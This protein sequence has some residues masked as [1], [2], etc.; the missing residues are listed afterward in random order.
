MKIEF[1][2][3]ISQT[4]LSTFLHSLWIGI[5][6]SV[7]AA[8]VLIFT[9]EK[10]SKL[11]YTLLCSLFFLFLA[12]V[13]ASFIF[14]L[15]INL[16]NDGYTNENLQDNETLLP[17]AWSGALTGIND[18][19][20]ANCDY[21]LLVWAAVFLFRIIQVILDLRYVSRLKS[22][23]TTPVPAE[24]QHRFQLLAEKIGVKRS[25]KLF[26]SAL[27]KIPVIIG[28]F[29]PVILVPVGA[30]N[31]LPVADVEA[32]LL[33]E[34]AHIRRLDYLVNFIQCIAGAVFFFNPGLLWI[35]SLLRQER[36]NC[37]DD[38]AIQ[39]TNGKGQYV[40]ALISFKEFSIQPRVALGL[41]GKTSLL[42]KRV[43]RLVQ[44]RNRMLSIRELVFVML[45]AGVLFFFYIN[46]NSVKEIETRVSAHYL[47][48]PA[49]ASFYVSEK[50][51]QEEE[52]LENDVKTIIFPKKNNSLLNKVVEE[53]QEEE[54]IVV[55]DNRGDFR[56]DEYMNANT[57]HSHNDREEIEYH[58][59]EAEVHRLQAEEDRKV[60]DLHRRQAMIHREEA[61]RHRI[62][63]EKYRKDA[64]MMRMQ[65]EH[66]REE[67]EQRRKQLSV[68]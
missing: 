30:I 28:H 37:C 5:I 25:V 43:T 38:L 17:G 16:T 3:T 1:L 19:L 22:Q 33:H 49:Q 51:M 35:S 23:Y 2:N 15:N 60:A 34:L 56:N 14:E 46:R 29:K 67:A 57:N 18:F 53:H 61:E 7:L 64:E 48:H 27:I 8:M 32:V 47:I 59:K 10:S 39:N 6:V 13:G 20:L 4:I 65:A 66:H 58:R 44:N 40:G 52:I 68:T 11:R 31:N 42:V 50:S 26:E 12:A 45:G 36:E 21:V 54:M 55:N 62:E 63:M 41:F 9:R 24:W